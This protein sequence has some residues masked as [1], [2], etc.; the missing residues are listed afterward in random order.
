[1][2]QGFKLPLIL[3]PAIRFVALNLKVTPQYVYNS[4]ASFAALSH[5]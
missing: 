5:H 3:P 2:P 1:M 4:W